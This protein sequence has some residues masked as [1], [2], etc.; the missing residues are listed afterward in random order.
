MTMLKRLLG[1]LHSAVFDTSP[2]AGLAFF[3]RHPD[4]AAWSVADEV[5]VATI[6]GQSKSYP[7]ATMTIG[8]LAGQLVIDGFEVSGLSAEFSGL[9]ASVLIDGSG[10][11]AT[12]NGDRLYAFRDYLRVLLG[13]YARELRTVKL[14][15]AEAIKQMVITQAEGEWLDLWGAIYN[16]PRPYNMNDADYQTLIPAEAFRVRVNGYAIEQA[17]L[18]LT[19]KVVSIE[20]P[21]GNIFRL[22]ESTLSGSHGFYD[23]S[24]IGYHLIRPVS[25]SSID[26]SDVLPV[27]ERN[28]AAGVLILDPETRLS[29]AVDGRINGSVWLG[30]QSISSSLVQIWTDSRL[31]YMVLSNEEITRNWDVMISNVVTMANL[32]PLLDPASI[33]AVRNIAKAAI[34]MSEG[35]AF[36]DENFVFPRAELT[37]LG[38]QM[39]TSDNLDLSSPDQRPVFKPVDLITSQTNARGELVVGGAT[40]V[41]VKPS[42]I[43]GRFVDASIN[44]TTSVSISAGF[45]WAS[46]GGWGEFP[47][48]ASQYETLRIEGVINRLHRYANYDLKEYLQ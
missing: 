23:G 14:Q 21:W 4:G 1:S 35:P 48:G 42:V 11:T 29:S 43:I 41:G 44:G 28:R 25:R 38:G 22:D 15:I 6:S 20:E 18:D 30:I 9:S 13:G 26:W 46:A 19:G 16:T 7:L 17:I 39:S 32:D 33:A 8:Q 27:I 10:N 3:I 2:D 5:L 40:D 24:N 37:Q 47:W 36:G 31:D 45:T 34:T 12:S